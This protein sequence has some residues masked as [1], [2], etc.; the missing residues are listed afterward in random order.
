MQVAEILAQS[1]RTHPD[2]MAACFDGSWKSYGE[3][4][5]AAQRFAGALVAHGVRTGERVA[6]LWENSF[7]Y[8]IA[9]FGALLAGAVE[10]SLNT[11]LKD[12]QLL[13]LIDD[14][15]A[16]ALVASGKLRRRWATI[17]TIAPSLRLLVTDA[18][19]FDT[20]S[21]SCDVKC[22]SLQDAASFAQKAGASGNRQ[23]DDLA[24]IVYTSGSTGR[25]KGVMLSHRNLVSN[26]A[27]IVEYLGLTPT[28]RMMVVLP[29]HYIY[30][31]S[32]LY[33]H[34]Y[35]G[36]SVVID[37]R[38]A[39]PSVILEAMEEHQV[40][41]FAGVPSTFSILMRKTDAARR[42]FSSLRLIT[43]AG[44][45]MAPALQGEVAAAFS[46]AVLFVMYGSTETSPRM[47]YLHPG[48]LESKRGSIG[49]GIPGVEVMVS[50]PDGSRQPPGV[51]GEIIAR[52]P[53]IMLGY[54]KDP[55]A[56][57]KV[58]RNG[59][60]LTGDLGYADDEGYIFLTGRA[61]DL[62]KVG[63]NR[64]SALE[65][66][67][68]IMTLEGVL[69][70]A[71]IGVPDQILGEAIKAFVV[72]HNGSLTEST[73]RQH[74]QHR[75]P[76]YGQPKIIEFCRDLPKNDAGK[77]LK[78]KLPSFRPDPSGGSSL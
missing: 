61:R 24:S 36:G 6:I 77:I 45:S 44:G 34:F 38:F 18:A 73:L 67:H 5:D 68:Q 32:L 69:E 59:Y 40:T 54:W 46:P 7:D 21:L 64:V 19:A 53:N 1:A 58:I 52:G 39:Y 12:P 14:C 71:V 3:L 25:P 42:H 9:H 4:F 23:D 8:I 27:S 28:D 43:Q 55:G 37:N 70:T 30:G 20:S 26:T 60:Y 22:L 16:V 75:L 51:T 50:D 56:T 33:T 11:D 41:C 74:L 47:T 62:I 35:S 15:E 31:R 78:A 29:F 63:G 72:A 65:V 17:V 10:V 48:L 76:T 66:E 49:Q 57:A 13:E 2:R